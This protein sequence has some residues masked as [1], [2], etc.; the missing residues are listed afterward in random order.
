MKSKLIPEDAA[1]LARAHDHHGRSKETKKEIRARLCRHLSYR[2]GR[3]VC[4]SWTNSTPLIIRVCR[5]VCIRVRVGFQSSLG[6]CAT[7]IVTLHAF[8]SFF[9][10][11]HR[12]EIHRRTAVSPQESF[13]LLSGCERGAGAKFARA[14]GSFWRKV[15][16]TLR[17]RGGVPALC[18]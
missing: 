8:L 7:S 14:R 5:I 10:F 18:Q 12:D 6:I 9:L 11:H 17:G 1:L 3:N 16:E 15:S 2:V 4:P 13:D